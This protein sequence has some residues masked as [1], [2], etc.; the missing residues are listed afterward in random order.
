MVKHAV[1]EKL[2]VII[3]MLR[4][5]KERYRKECRESGIDGSGTLEMLSNSIRDIEEVK[6]NIW[7]SHAVGWESAR[8]V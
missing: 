8:D 1:E 5:E 7:R 6:N 3:R 4:E 2:C